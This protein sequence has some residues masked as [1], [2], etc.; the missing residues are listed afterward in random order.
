LQER[1]KRKKEKG[2][3]QSTYYNN[4]RVEIIRSHC[5][6]VPVFSIQPPW[7]GVP[8]PSFSHPNVKTS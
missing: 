4:A 2:N 5:I 8:F 6:P 1:E 7:L 3:Q